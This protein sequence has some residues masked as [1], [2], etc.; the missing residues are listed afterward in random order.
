[1]ATTLDAICPKCNGT[2]DTG[3]ECNDCDFDWQNDDRTEKQKYVDEWHRL[4]IAFLTVRDIKE[5]R[6]DFLRHNVY[7]STVKYMPY[8]VD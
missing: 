4:E 6:A 2:T 7:G 5:E 3:G 8:D 1:M